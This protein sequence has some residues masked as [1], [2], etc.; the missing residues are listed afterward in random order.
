MGIELR[1]PR[2]TKDVKDATNRLVNLNMKN[3][4]KIAK[5]VFMIF[6]RWKIKQKKLMKYFV[7]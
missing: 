2:N 4:L 6:R 1:I 5:N 3:I 7:N